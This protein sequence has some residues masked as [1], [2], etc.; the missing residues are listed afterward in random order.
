MLPVKIAV[1]P[2]MRLFIHHVGKKK[3]TK[4]HSNRHVLTLLLWSAR[5]AGIIRTLACRPCARLAKEG[6][7]YI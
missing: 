1:N 5:I 7:V 2:G 4:G 6:T 3:N